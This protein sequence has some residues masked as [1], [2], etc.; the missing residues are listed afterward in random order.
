VR[1]GL[2]HPVREMISGSPGEAVPDARNSPWLAEISQSEIEL[3]H[4]DRGFPYHGF[5][6][7]IRRDD[8]PGCAMEKSIC[9]DPSDFRR[10]PLE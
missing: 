3:G 1:D 10:N 4:R 9:T 7:I 6:G 5:A 8:E 2:E